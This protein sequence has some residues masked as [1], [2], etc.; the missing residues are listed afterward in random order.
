MPKSPST[1]EARLF[2]LTPVSG[3]KV[4]GPRLRAALARALGKPVSQASY[5]SATAAL[6]KA[7][8][9]AVDDR[10]QAVRRLLTTSHR[11]V[12]VV[13]SRPV[14][15]AAAREKRGKSGKSL[16]KATPVIGYRH[17]ERRVNNPE[18]GMVTPDT[19][20]VEPTS[21]WA[22]DPN[23]DPQLQWAGKSERTSFEVDTVSLHVHE[24]IEPAT[25]VSAM[26]TRQAKDG[27]GPATQ[28]DMFAAWFEKTLP[29]REAIEFYKHDRGWANRLIAGD[30]LLVM[31]SLI[32]KESMAGKV[33]MIYLDPPYGI[34]YG[35]N[36][37]PFV[38]KRDVKDRKD[39]DL[40]QEPEMIKAFRDTWELGIHSY[41]TYLRDRLLLGR[42]LLADTGSV[43]V[44]ISDEN[45]HH[46]REIMDEV[47]GPENVIAVI[48]IE[49]TS[50]STE[51]FLAGT[52]D[53]LLW[54]S[55]DK[56]QTKYQPVFKE[57]K[58]GQTGATGYTSVRMPNGKRLPLDGEA[59]E[60]GRIYAL[61]NL[62][63][64]S[65]GR[66]KGEGASCWFPVPLKGWSH[67]P[68]MSTRWKTNE[69]GMRRLL[70]G[71]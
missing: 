46:V 22:Y 33:Q 15:I 57:K 52:T 18:V 47:F 35:S 25:L 8:K 3:A 9:L 69:D 40:T 31:N 62:A 41:L 11:P 70:R 55:K 56:T 26:R 5:D 51:D 24:R 29:Y 67:L 1:I 7:G 60:N 65:V 10:T 16:A 39:E 59:P 66:E 54:Y 64:Q 37:Q 23:L 28:T 19:D 20:P 6:V 36:F 4:N 21:K 12:R 17:E 27:S 68:S 38:N 45:L 34:K 58:P 2:D 71:G 14:K 42:Q 44:Q 63:S 49:K 61:D 53:Y 43:F 50:S 32:Q 48:V 30:S 13:S